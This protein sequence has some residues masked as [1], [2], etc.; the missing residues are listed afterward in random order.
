MFKFVVTALFVVSFNVQAAE[1]INPGIALTE[2]AT[3]L[4]NAELQCK[5]SADCD[6]VAAG[7]RACGGPNDYIVVSKLNQN[8]AEVKFLAKASEDKEDIYNAENGAISICSLV[9]PPTV[10]CVKKICVRK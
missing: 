3:L 2:A 1:S 7:S 4:S 8:L 9:S 6:Y 5:T 10:S